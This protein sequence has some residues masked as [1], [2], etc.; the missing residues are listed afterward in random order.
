MGCYPAASIARHPPAVVLSE[1]ASVGGAIKQMDQKSVRHALVSEDGIR[2]QGIVSAKDLLNLL[3]GGEKFASV[4]A[5][6]GKSVQ[7]LL[8]SPILPIVNRRPILG[9][10]SSP[11]PELMSTM[12]RHDIGMLPLI[13]EDGTIWGVLSERHLFKLFE[14]QQMFVRVSEI[15]STPLITLDIRT[16]LLDAMK[17]MIK[18][19]IR[20]VL[21]TKGLDVWGIVTVKDVMRFLASPYVDA[22]VEKGLSDYLL[23]V[24][25]SKIATA[26]PKTV[27]PD[28][29]LC[30]AVKVMNTYNIGSLIV[31]SDGKPIGMLTERD[32]L[33]KLPKLRGVE[34]MTDITR[35]R[36]LVG[37][38][39]F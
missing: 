32:F 36:V 33:L 14:A 17:V 5:V 30:D 22:L 23:N 11:L 12:A 20:R 34:F 38:I 28:L 31:V 37:R 35:N 24:N 19:D 6:A 2:L 9:R 8:N 26:N 27:D 39:H 15:M 4:Q 29:D 10:V 16:S 13:N 3:G 25:I 18:N 1:N 21:V 7:T